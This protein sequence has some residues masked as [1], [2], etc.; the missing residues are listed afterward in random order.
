[1]QFKFLSSYEPERNEPI[2]KP[3]STVEPPN[4]LSTQGWYD[5]WDSKRKSFR[6]P[7]RSK[8]WMEPKIKL[9]K[10]EKLAK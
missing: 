2:E 5:N 4:A 8:T 3:Y 9:E 10:S 1:M 7:E 6:N